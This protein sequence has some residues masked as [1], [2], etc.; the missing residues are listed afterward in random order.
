MRV[1]RGAMIAI[2]LLTPVA[3]AADIVLAARTIRAQSI[4]APSDIVIKP[5]EVAGVASSAQDVVGLETRVALYAGRPIRIADLGPPAVIERNQIVQLIY[6][7]D[8]LSIAADG[9]SLSRA[10]PGEMVRVM[11]LSS[12]MTISGRASPDGRVFVSN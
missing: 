5:G 3:A 8:G 12:R 2:A 11:N 4:I 1:S 7:Q 6:R 10:G 9:R